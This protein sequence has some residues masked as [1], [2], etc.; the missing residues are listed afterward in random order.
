[1]KWR[2][3]E[4]YDAVPLA[5]AGFY[6]WLLW[7]CFIGPDAKSIAALPWT[8]RIVAGLGAIWM[9][10]RIGKA[11]GGLWKTLRDAGARR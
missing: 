10:E 5:F 6:G 2:N 8:A 1:V 3:L 4:P 11:I 9:L 7:R